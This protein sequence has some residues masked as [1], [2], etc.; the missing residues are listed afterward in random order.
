MITNAIKKWIPRD[1]Q[2]GLVRVFSNEYLEYS[3]SV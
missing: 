3:L 1:F 2:C